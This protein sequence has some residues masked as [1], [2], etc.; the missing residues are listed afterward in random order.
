MSRRKVPIEKRQQ[1][2]GD[3]LSLKTFDYDEGEI[4]A[5]II[6]GELPV[7]DSAV[8]LFKLLEG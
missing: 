4:K 6:S 8:D 3:R 1:R 5:K 7:F 2:G